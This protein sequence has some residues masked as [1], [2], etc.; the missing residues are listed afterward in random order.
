MLVGKNNDI[1]V[2]DD[3]EVRG[4]GNNNRVFVAPSLFRSLLIDIRGDNCCLEIEELKHCHRARIF[5]RNGAT[6]R[7]G[8]GSTIQELSLV[9]SSADVTIGKNCM[10]SNNVTIRTTDAH[11]IYDKDSR[12]L[13][14]CPKPIFIG[15]HVWLGQMAMIGKGAV[16]GSGTVIGSRSLVQNT[17]IPEDCVAAGTPA[18]VI[19]ENIIWDVRV[20]DSLPT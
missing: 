12:E 3:V 6:V 15:D 10:F 9:T 14:N 5:I 7:F 17:Q 1:D 2:P 16:V 20:E 8:S 13:I 19:R 18:K 11:G 4:Q